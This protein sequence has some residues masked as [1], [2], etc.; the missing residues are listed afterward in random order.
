M[1]DEYPQN[2]VKSV[3]NVKMYVEGKKLPKNSPPVPFHFEESKIKWNF[4][5]KKR[6]TLDKLYV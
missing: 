1:K 4:D 3:I 6:M 5:Y 2:D